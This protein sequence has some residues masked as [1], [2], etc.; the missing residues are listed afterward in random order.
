MF[1]LRLLYSQYCYH[2]LVTDNSMDTF[3]KCHARAFMA[4]G[5]APKRIIKICCRDNIIYDAKS[6]TRYNYFLYCC[7]SCYSPNDS[8]KCQVDCGEDIKFFRRRFVATVLHNDYYKLK[9]QVGKWITT[10]INLGMH[11]I[12]RL[13]V[14]KQFLNYEKIKLN[15]VSQYTLKK[16]MK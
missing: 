15:R 8:K 9:G 6:L 4:L 13:I 7:G 1:C 12:S 14:K 16:A 11:P 3:L 5:G 2:T 10:V